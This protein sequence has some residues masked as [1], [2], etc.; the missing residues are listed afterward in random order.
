M[1]TKEC[2]NCD[3]KI[4]DTETKC[5]ACGVEIAELESEVGAVDRALKILEKRKKQAA[6]PEPEPTPEPK[7]KKSFLHNLSK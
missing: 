4:G 7:K 1:A 2:I 6:P 3:A 5:P